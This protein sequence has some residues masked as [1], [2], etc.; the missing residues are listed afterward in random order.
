MTAK[1]HPLT[2][3]NRLIAGTGKRRVRQ[4]TTAGASSENL[5][6]GQDV[7][8]ISI[9]LV[10]A[11]Q[12]KVAKGLEDVIAKFAQR[13]K[14]SV[15]FPPHVTILGGIPVTQDFLDNSIIP[16][17]YKNLQGYKSVAC[18]FETEPH[19]FPKWSQA[20][21]M[22]MDNST[23]FTDLVQET[24]DSLIESLN[25]EARKGNHLDHCPDFASFPP[26]PG[27]PHLSLYY[28]EESVPSREEI[29][30]TLPSF[31]FSFQ[32]TRVAIWRTDPSSTAGVSQWRQLDAIDLVQSL[33][34]T[35]PQDLSQKE[36]PE[37]KAFRDELGGGIRRG[38]RH[39]SLIQM[40]ALA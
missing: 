8:K 12:D 33:P 31:P 13:P 23:E 39:N 2:T 5:C 7:F 22:L 11:P 26:A 18:N 40:R 16:N 37:E 19:F 24:R 21:V 28:G 3:K 35:T 36:F 9:W 27:F 10:P 25:D 38:L 15:A 6:H 29:M 4:V 34:Q 17:L 1:I 32:G 14:S 20:A 30:N